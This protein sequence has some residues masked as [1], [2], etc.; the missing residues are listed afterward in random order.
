MRLVF[1]IFSSLVI[2]F[3]VAF[4]KGGFNI[5]TTPITWGY[6]LFGI[7]MLYGVY[8][9]FIFKIYQKNQTFIFFATTPFYKLLFDISL[10]I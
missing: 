8:P 10:S 1:K 4:P 7:V 6:I 2:I 9:I 5:G 3:L